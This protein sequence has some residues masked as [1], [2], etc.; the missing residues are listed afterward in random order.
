M[1]LK[2]TFFK[3]ICLLLFALF[4]GQSIHAQVYY[5]GPVDHTF[6]TSGSFAFTHHLQEFDVLDPNGIIIDSVTIYPTEPVA[7]DAYTIVVQDANQTVIASHSDTT[8]AANS[9][10]ERVHVDLFVPQGTGYRLGFG[11]N[12]GMIRNSTGAS[13]P[14]TV[15][16]VISFTGNTFMATYWYFFYNIRVKLHSQPTDV[17][18]SGGFLYPDSLDPNIVCQGDQDALVYLKNYGPNELADVDIHA[19]VNGVAQPAYSW[20]GSLMPG[21]S[22]LVNLGTVN[23]DMAYAPYSLKAYT[24][25]PNGF[26]DTNNVND[27]LMV[28]NLQVLPPLVEDIQPG[29]FVGFCDND[30]VMVSLQGSGCDQF[31]WYK[32][33]QPV[34]EGDDSLLYIKTAGMYNVW[35]SDGVCSRMSDSIEA[36][37]SPAPAAMVSTLSTTTFCY[38][39]SVIITT[40]ELPNHTYQ[41]MR[42]QDP[43][44]GATHHQ[45]SA[46][47]AG[48][49]NV[50]VT[51]MHNCS[52]L[53]IDVTVNAKPLHQVPFGTDTTAFDDETVVLDAGPGADSYNWSTGDTSQSITVDSTGIGYGSK[54]FFVTTVLDHCETTDSITVT[55][56]S[57]NY[58]PVEEKKEPKVVI[59]P[60]PSPGN[61]TLKTQGLETNQLEVEF[62]NIKGQLLSQGTYVVDKKTGEKE[63]HT[64]LPKGV[65]L[66]SINT[67]KQS[68]KK[69]VVIQ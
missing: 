52:T 58:Y 57:S 64:R 23:F 43:I 44:A 26:P 66:M 46:K 67:G 16:G 56:Q 54:T 30:S 35:Y 37:A 13:Y 48:I 36:I 24:C 18:L 40:D 49:Y 34:P 5:V 25:T 33:G 61:F 20:S 1:L 9:Q 12:P 21:D 22:T 3:I 10:P 62:Y 8:T 28:Q 63:I 42:D 50:L 32:N 2:S 47:E 19:E 29:Y 27:T 55:F 6:G 4:S 60:N 39:D 7:G 69:K 11:V 59:F 68:F 31:Q 53:S 17:G 14:Y 51:N 38:G 15:P 65:Y 45:Y 41:W